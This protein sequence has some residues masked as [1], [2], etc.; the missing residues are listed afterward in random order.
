[1]EKLMI[2]IDLGNISLFPNLKSWASHWDDSPQ[3]S[4]DSRL[5]EN[6]VWSLEFAQES[7]NIDPENSL[8]LM[9][10]NLPNPIQDLC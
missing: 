10:T 7:I 6:R 5:R 8:V 2:S 9:E 4:H 3:I 1:M